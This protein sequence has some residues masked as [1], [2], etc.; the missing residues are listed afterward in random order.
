MKLVDEKEE[1][2]DDEELVDVGEKRIESD[3]EEEMEP[4]IEEEVVE[5]DP[6]HLWFNKRSFTEETRRK[7][8]RYCTRAF[9]F[10]P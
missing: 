8:T 1:M 6:Y 10:P 4:L 3:E 5:Q 7:Q 9:P 2:S